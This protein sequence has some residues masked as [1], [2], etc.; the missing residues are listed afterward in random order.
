M[1]WP[2]AIA[3]GA[4][5][6]GGVLQNRASAKAAERQMNFQS[7][8]SNTA[9]QRG[10]EDMRRAGLNPML[11]YQKGGATTPSGAQ[12]PMANVIGNAVNSAMA[13][14]RQQEDLKLVRSQTTKT[15]QE[16]RER[17]ALADRAEIQNLGYTAAKK[18]ID[19]PNTGVVIKKLEDI[20]TPTPKRRAEQNK[21]WEE[22]KKQLRNPNFYKEYKQKGLY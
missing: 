6:L 18:I 11:A 16:A 2:A 14:R 13:M 3:G 19:N 7:D 21:A 10:M 17:K 20:V 8:M 12:A 22:R 9:Y 4:A 1:V 15:N 5:L